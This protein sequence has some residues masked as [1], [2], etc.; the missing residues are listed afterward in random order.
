VFGAGTADHL[1]VAGLGQRVG[2]DAGRRAHQHGI[3]A[4][5]FVGQLL[6]IFDRVA[7]LDEPSGIAEQGQTVSM[8]AV[9][10]KDSHG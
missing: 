2:G 8:N 4:F 5:Q 6:G 1:H 9:E 7:G 3:E 10:R